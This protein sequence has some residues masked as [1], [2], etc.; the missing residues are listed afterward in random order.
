MMVRPRMLHTRDGTRRR[1]RYPPPVVMPRRRPPA[2]LWW[3]DLPNLL[4]DGFDTPYADQ[5]EALAALDYVAN[6]RLQY[7]TNWDLTPTATIDGTEFTVTA[8]LSTTVFGFTA[9]SRIYA[10]ADIDYTIAATVVGSAKSQGVTLY[11]DD[12][13]TIV[14]SGNA[15]SGT[16]VIP[17]PGTYWVFFGA[18]G[19][20]PGDPTS[21]E[22]TFTIDGGPGMVIGTARA[23]WDDGGGVQ[24]ELC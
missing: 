22:A 17:A 2:P 18:G 15:D 19:I 12:Q 7:A 10:N 5:A 14:D 4:L 6:C 8:G 16:L 23:A 3:L 24:Y 20:P 11:D 9:V 13:T 1:G 21:L